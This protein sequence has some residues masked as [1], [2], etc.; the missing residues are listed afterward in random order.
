L[1]TYLQD[2]MAG[3]TAG[4]ELAMKIAGEYREPP[5][6]SFLEEL[7]RDISCDRDTLAGVLTSFDLKPDPVKQAVGWVG[8]KLSRLKL[9]DTIGHPAL[10]QLMEFEVLSL[11]IEGKLEL[12]RALSGIADAHV[13][14]AEL[15]L[16][17]LIKRAEAQRAG[18]EEHRMEAAAAAF[19]PES[20]A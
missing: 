13:E 19:A 11:G 16:P 12:W 4:V 7:A 2:H 10:K 14:L 5:L 15:D 3:A 6:G 9:S 17:G 18:L 1:K 20:P 8:E